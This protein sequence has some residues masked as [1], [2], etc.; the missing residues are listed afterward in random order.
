MNFVHVPA[1]FLI[2]FSGCTLV[3]KIHILST[4]PPL[5]QIYRFFYG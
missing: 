5:E 3:D 2:D 1:A 4:I